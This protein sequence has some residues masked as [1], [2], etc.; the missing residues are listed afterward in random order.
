MPPIIRFCISGFKE[1]GKYY[2][3]H[4]FSVNREEHQLQWQIKRKN[5]DLHEGYSNSV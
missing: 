2:Y 5:V 3:A 4:H 1:K